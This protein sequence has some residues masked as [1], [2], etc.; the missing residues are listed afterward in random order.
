MKESRKTTAS[1]YVENRDRSVRTSM[2]AEVFSRE[3]RLKSMDHHSRLCSSLSNSLSRHQNRVV[4]YSILSSHILVKKFL[5]TF[6]FELDK[7]DCPRV[8]TVPRGHEADIC[9]NLGVLEAVARAK[10][11]SRKLST[12]H[13][14][15]AIHLSRL[16]T[17]KSTFSRI[18][19]YMKSP[20]HSSF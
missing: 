13:H 20:V 9:P 11:N 18:Y 6:C 19:I 16:C 12:L 17:A 4:L 10:K 8:L 3:T 14:A 15:S 2:W 1:E 7:G 5:P